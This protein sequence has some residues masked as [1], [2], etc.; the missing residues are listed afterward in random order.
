MTGVNPFVSVQVTSHGKSLTPYLA[1]KGFMTGVNPFVSVQVTR[2]DKILTAYITKK[3]IITDVTQLVSSK[4]NPMCSL[5]RLVICV[6][7]LTPGQL[8]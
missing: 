2:P 1:N 6:P 5:P 7:I 3:G 8:H 4:Y